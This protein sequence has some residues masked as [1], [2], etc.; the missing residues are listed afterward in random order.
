MFDHLKHNH[1]TTAQWTETFSTVT[2][3]DDCAPAVGVT[4]MRHRL[5]AGPAVGVTQT[6][7]VRL[8]R[9]LTCGGCDLNATQARGGCDGNVTQARGGCDG[10]VTQAQGG[11]DG[12]VTQARGGCDGNVTPGGAQVKLGE[13]AGGSRHA[14]AE[15]FRFF[16]R[17]AVGK[18]DADQFRSACGRLGIDLTPAEAAALLRRCDVSATR[19]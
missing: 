7:Q 6:S 13:R 14:L 8:H 18:L 19:A 2:F 4:Q 5:G 1:I 16:D 9:G 11:C 3:G 10:N 17:K 12:N 15:C